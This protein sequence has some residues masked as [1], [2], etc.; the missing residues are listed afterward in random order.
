MGA[1]AR[2]ASELSHCGLLVAGRRHALACLD[3]W[4]RVLVFRTTPGLVHCVLSRSD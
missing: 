1:F 3:R 2:T 4:G